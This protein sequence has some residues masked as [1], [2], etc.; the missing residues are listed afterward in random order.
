MVD[1]NQMVA[2]VRVVRR[3]SFAVAARDFGVPPSTISRRIAALEQRLGIV[4]LTRTTRSLRLTEAGSAYF[5]RCASV[6][7]QAE[8][9]EQ[10]AMRLAKAPRGTLRVTAPAIFA[11]AVV[12]PTLT[13]YLR[14]YHDVRIDF[15]AEDRTVD[16]VREGYDLAFRVAPA[17]PSTSL[18]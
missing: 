18:V 9:A 17:L 10:A 13:E 6:V 7:G 8:D 12:I 3:G 1:L 5:E 15:T 4:L 16:L 11:R 14:H 2:F